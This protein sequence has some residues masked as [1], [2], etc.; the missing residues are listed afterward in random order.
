M[1]RLIDFFCKKKK[2]KWISVKDKM[3][4]NGEQVIAYNGK[5]VEVGLYCFSESFRYFD[6]SKK[7]HNITHWMPLPSP[8]KS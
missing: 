4:K 1:K 5:S 6:Y 2:N 7:N 3:P 8:P